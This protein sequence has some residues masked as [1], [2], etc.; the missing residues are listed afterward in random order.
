M[1]RKFWQ[2]QIALLACIVVFTTTIRAED[3]A[4]WI[5]KLASKSW[6]DKDQAC[7]RLRIYGTV[8]CVPALAKLLTDEKMAHTALFAMEEMKFPEVDQALRE[9]LGKTKGLVK[10]GIIGS[11]GTRGDAKAVPELIKLLKDADKEVSASAASALGRIATPEAVDALAGL[12]GNVSPSAAEAS[13][14][15]ARSLLAQGKKAEAAKIYKDL[16]TDK[17]PQPVRLGAFAGLLSAEP[18]EAVA[19]VVQAMT[20][21]DAML[22]AVAV[23]N[24]DLLEGEGVAERLAAEFPKLTPETQVSMIDALASRGNVGVRP[25]VVSA[26]ASSNAEVRMA[27]AKALGTI[28]DA[29]CVKALCQAIAEGK[30]STERAI[31]VTSLRILKGDGIDAAIIECMK[32]TPP[33]GRAAVISVLRDRGALAAVPELIAQVKGGDTAVHGAAWDAL[34]KLAEPKEVPGL[35]K[36]LTAMEGDAGRPA[37]ELAIVQI[38]RKVTEEGAK[39]DP[40]L[41]ALKSAS[42]TPARCSLLRVLGGIGS[43]KGLETIQGAFK[44]KDAAVQEAALRAL[45]NWP[46]VKALGAL[47]SI[48]KNAADEK[49]RVL[50]LRGC[51]RLLSLGQCSAEEALKGYTDLIKLAKRAD[52]KK[53]MLNGLGKVADPAALAMVEPFRSDAETRAEAELATLGILEGIKSWARAETKAAATK[54]AAE[55]KDQRVRDRAKAILRHTKKYQDYIVD[56]Q[57]AGPYTVRGKLGAALQNVAFDPEKTEPKGVPWRL[58]PL[59]SGKSAPYMLDLR[60]TMNGENRVAYFRTW[61]HSNKDQ[62]ALLD[63]GTDDSNKVWLNGKLVHADATAGAAEPGEHKIKTNLKQGWNALLLKV[64]QGTSKWEFCFRIRSADGKA[65][66]GL[67]TNAQHV[68]VRDYGKVDFENNAPE[69][70][71]K[72]KNPIKNIPPPTTGWKQL[73]NGKDLTGWKKTGAGIFKIEEGC[74]LGTQTDGKGG[75]LWTEAEYDNFELRVT[76]RVGWPANSGFWFRH[77]GKRG[78]QFDVLKYKKPVG[79]SGTLY[80]PGKLFIFANLDESIENRDGWNE[81]RIRADGQEIT[82]WLNGKQTGTCKDDT[83]SKGKIGIQIHGGNGFK[84]MKIYIKKMELCP[85]GK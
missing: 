2:T 75:D 74:L 66:Q 68:R 8:K 42:A 1:T 41:A 6:Q 81:A 29:S 53:L 71:Q 23:R 80:C 24:L 51:V 60:A 17:W 16:Q 5:Q 46:N 34:G 59:V 25:A 11:I 19:R 61:V 32:S 55:A 63:Y 43:S 54:L 35:M 50:S 4:Q 20:G 22:R 40:V 15:A 52:D 65:A 31:A 12:R 76:Y 33:K 26:M 64:V 10:V 48:L 47:M 57:Y 82:F 38:S 27:A 13:L 79:F 83:L 58:L 7:R 62:A 56:W 18:E 44:D 85:L 49:Q 69:A 84:N 78:Y 30:S 3:E 70:Q 14:K 21:K 37:A 73:H 36:V 77:D 72:P 9:A 39:S 45:L 67:R 28:G